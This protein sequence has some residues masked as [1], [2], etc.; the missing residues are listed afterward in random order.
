LLGFSRQSL[1]QPQVIDLNALI[2]E[3]G[4]MLRRLI[5]EDILYTM[6]LDP[7]LRRVKVD[8][9]LLDQAMMNLAVNARDAMPQG[10]KL[11]V[12]TSNVNF[13]GEDVA[14]HPNCKAGHHVMLAMSDTGIGMPPEVTARIFEPFYTTKEVGKGTGLGL[15]MVFGIVEQ[16]GGSIEV[17]SE[18]GRG[19]TF[20]IYLPAVA[21]QVSAKTDMVSPFG[22]GGPE[23][24]LLVEDDERVRGLALWCLKMQGYQ[25]LTATDGKDALRV[26]KSHRGPLDLILTDV[27]MPNIGGLELVRQLKTSSP[28]LKVLYMSGYTDDAVVRHGLID[29]EVAFIQKPYTPQVLLHKVRQILDKKGNGS[30]L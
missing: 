4:K 15:A 21:E 6:V 7:D 16:S 24:I 17:F 12:E 28:D 22:S 19:T 26:L 11:T 20:K 3:T 27:V 10:G 14:V 9:G 29:S 23:T 1:L 25:V 18:P 30:T 8:P 13:S 2:T 5:G